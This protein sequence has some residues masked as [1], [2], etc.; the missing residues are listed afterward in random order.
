MGA[1]S[2]EVQIVDFVKLILWSSP[3]H[4]VQAVSQVEYGASVAVVSP[5][6]GGDDHFRHDVISE[7]FKAEFGLNLVDDSVA[8]RILFF[9][10]IN[11]LMDV[12]YR[13]EGVDC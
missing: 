7:V 4:L 13:D 3:E 9:V 5:I 12:G 2:N 11:V 1:S 8:V 6:F 10:P